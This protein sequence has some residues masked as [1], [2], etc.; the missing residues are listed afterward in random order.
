MSQIRQASLCHRVAEGQ[1]SHCFFDLW[2]VKRKTTAQRQSCRSVWWSA[3][4]TLLAGCI[5][6]TYGA[7]GLQSATTWPPH[8]STSPRS[9]RLALVSGLTGQIRPIPVKRVEVSFLAALRFYMQ[10]DIKSGLPI[11][12]WQL[13]WCYLT[14]FW[15]RIDVKKWTVCRAGTQQI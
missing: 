3:P 10:V 8:Q 6:Y 7:V 2:S 14:H 4:E 12:R 5:K 11:R 1:L 9:F 15:F 13:W